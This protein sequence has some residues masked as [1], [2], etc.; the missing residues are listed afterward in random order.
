M[1]LVAKK[2]PPLSSHM[3]TN[4]IR[5]TL[6]QFDDRINCMIYNRLPEELSQNRGV[7][8][9]RYR[10]L[11]ILGLALLL[12]SARVIAQRTRQVSTDNPAFT[13]DSVPLTTDKR[14]GL[15]RYVSSVHWPLR[16]KRGETLR[17]QLSPDLIAKIDSSY[18]P[19]LLPPS[20]S[21]DQIVLGV[22][23]AGYFANITSNGNS[24]V[25]SATR[26]FFVLPEL[27]DEQ[28]RP[29][30][31]PPEYVRGL[32]AWIGESEGVWRIAWEENGVAYQITFGCPSDGGTEC[33]V[34]HARSL[35]E[36]LTFVGG[37]K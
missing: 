8:M 17:A 25:I 15:Q 6:Y 13:G 20:V 30:I 27:Y 5:L 1:N 11:L 4:E 10:L 12:V 33:D 3:A 35:A 29:K 19:V 36:S 26:I 24:L 16:D 14:G 2:E 31:K 18:V 9:R 34:S 37:A 32:S 21:D 7:P 22:D 23:S 28:G